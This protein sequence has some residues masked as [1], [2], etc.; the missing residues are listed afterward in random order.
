MARTGGISHLEN[1]PQRCAGEMLKVESQ[2]KR[3]RP[4]GNRVQMLDVRS[5]EKRRSCRQNT[6]LRQKKTLDW[7]K[8]CGSGRWGRNTSQEPFYTQE[9]GVEQIFIGQTRLRACF[10]QK[11]V[12][13]K[14]SQTKGQEEG[15]PSR[16]QRK[17]KTHHGAQRTE[18]SFQ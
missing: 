16:K 14:K 1:L 4:W 5:G 9:G 6:R 13:G 11:H 7:Q 10:T 17:K 2:E 3:R 15:H 18:S 12:D 8:L